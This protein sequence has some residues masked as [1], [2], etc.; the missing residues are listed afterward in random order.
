MYSKRVFK[1]YHSTSARLTL[2]PNIRVGPRSHASTPARPHARTPTRLV[3]VYKGCRSQPPTFHV[4]CLDIFTARH[5]H[6]YSIIIV[7][8]FNLF[9]PLLSRKDN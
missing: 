5:K 3:D 4:N 9:R 2:D 8:Y 1:L 6:P 7:N